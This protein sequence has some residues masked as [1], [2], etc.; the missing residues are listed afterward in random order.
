MSRAL[1]ARPTRLIMGGLAALTLAATAVA[2]APSATALGK[3]KCKQ[4]AGMAMV[5]PIMSHNQPASMHMHQFFGN[6]GWL[7]KGNAANYTDLMNSKTTNCVNAADTAAY[8]TPVLRYT[9]TGAAVPI[10][11]FTAYYR[12]W[13][14]VGGPDFGPGRAFPQDTRLVATKF[15]WNCG[16]FSGTRTQ[17]VPSVPDCSGLSGKPGQTLTLHVDFPT[18]WNGKNPVHA[19]TAVGNTSDNANYAY[20]LGSGK[21]KTCPTT[22]PIKM[23]ALRE[24]LQF[25]YTGKGADVELSSDRMMGTSDGRSAHADFWNTWQPTGF[26]SMVK[27][28]VNG[29]GTYTHAECG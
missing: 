5:D 10:Q 9:A 22:H 1:G 15:E 11:S 16:Q 3:I 4:L 27:N 25:A 18:C 2:A 24:T 21:T 7:S 13:T 29:L 12:P 28:C 26:A 6:T 17:G 19:T 14:G 8:W 23:I 20:A